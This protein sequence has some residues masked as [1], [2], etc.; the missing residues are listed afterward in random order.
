[1]ALPKKL[2]LDDMQ[3]TWA[4]ALDPVISNILV[5][6]QLLRNIPLA[7]GSNAISHSLQRNLNGWF[8][9]SPKGSAVVYQAAQQPNPTLTLTVIASA[10]ITTDLWVF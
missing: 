3:T 9:V 4:T 7:I 5:N 6:G 10:A 8:L 1:M 2:K